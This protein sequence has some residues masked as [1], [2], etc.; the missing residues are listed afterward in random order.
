MDAECW[1]KAADIF[2]VALD[3]EGNERDA[4]VERATA[5]DAQVR[6]EV[7]VLLSSHER[8][9][10]FLEIAAS[11]AARDA[12]VRALDRARHVRRLGDYE[13]LQEIAAGGMGIVFRA[14]QISLNRIVALKTVVGGPLAS[15]GNV[16]RFQTEAEAAAQLDHPNIVPIYEVGE[17]DGVHYY[18]MRLIEGGSLLDRIGEFALP[19][20]STT[21]T[22]HAE[23]AA[24]QS[25]IAR[26][27]A[28]VA[29]GVHCAHQHGILHRD[30]KPANILIDS[31]GEPLI[32]DFGIAKL[33][34]GDGGA[35]RTATMIGTPNYMAP[36]QAAGDARALTTAADVFSLGAILY[37]LLTARQPFQ[38][39]T[40][41]E[42]LQRVVE[43]EPPAPRTCNKAIDRDL[44]T[45]C[46]KALLKNPAQRYGS[47]EAFAD[48][49]DRWLTGE[50]I[51]ARP[52]SPTERAWLWCRRKPALAA[53]SAGLL[54]SIVSGLVISLWQWRRAEGTA[55]L[56]AQNLYVSDV[57]V[58]FGAWESGRIE[59]ARELLNGQ[60]PGLG[61]PDLR[62]FEWRY[63]FGLTRPKELLTIQT[64]AAQIWG[65]AVSPDGR[66]LAT[67]AGD[68]TIQLWD[69]PSGA[70]LGSLKNSPTIIYCLAFSPVDGTLLAAATDTL[71][72][73]LWDVS[74]RQLVGR[75]VHHASTFS[76][77]F[78]PDGRK[79]ATVAGYPYALDTPA[80]LSL[81]D[82]DT[83]QKVRS[84]DAHQA[85][86]AFVDISRD[87]NL[88]AITSGDGSVTIW[89]LATHLPAGRL[90]GHKG[91]AICARFSPSG[92][93][94]ATGGIDGTVRL[95]DV[96]TGQMVA[97]LGSHEGAVYSVA[98][99][100]DGK[101]LLSG[102]LD[103][104]ARL[105][106]VS[107]QRPVGVL[108]GHGS[109][110]FSVSYA[111][112]GLTVVTASLDGTA[113]IWSSSDAPEFEIFDRYPG[114]RATVDFSPDG[115]WLA[116]SADRV[117]LWDA[118]RQEKIVDIPHSYARFSDDSSVLATTSAAGVT[119]WNVTGRVPTLVANIGVDAP[120]AR[121][122]AFSPD[123]QLLAVAI[124]TPSP[125]IEIR[126]VARRDRIAQL[127]E[128][129]SRGTIRSYA[130][131][132]D[133]L[134]LIA[135]YAD[136]RVRLWNAR[137]W[138]AG[139]LLD[140]H[141]KS[142]DAMAF[143]PDGRLFATGSL[144]TT[145][146][147]W[148]ATF[149]TAPVAL[150]GDNGAVSTLAFAP[151]GE[152]LAVGSVDATVKFWNVRT[153]REVATIKA[154][155][156]VVTSV[157]FSP[158]GRMLAT[159]S[160]DQTMKLWKAPALAEIGR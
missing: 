147:L 11:V 1:H 115:R 129:P 107:A 100:P 87:G 53:L 6:R 97:V 43:Q 123:G 7:D 133:G 153:R 131:S 159:A 25:R 81:W 4:F 109:R 146:Q 5:G 113:K 89:N 139:R 50:P 41:L 95:W 68:G 125:L 106:D 99:S 28:K 155:D 96:A 151:D 118:Q 20:P 71:E 69:L 23:M 54:L 61:Q 93:M 10:G 103:H 132:R 65:S 114:S 124:E 75:L 12:H 44:E 141:T 55:A 157:A 86:S 130:F 16:A 34:A 117:T 127:V 49:L 145:V 126:S 62:T 22:D 122:P 88:L 26:L 108:R 37:Q 51:A 137:T 85:S 143:S 66:I 105:W 140:A 134:R 78:T 144:D 84:F 128:T 74:K 120:P 14:R 56:M 21:I 150:R 29:R 112:D 40:P 158:D 138:T 39:A 63:L 9:G 92:S 91:M 104:T 15:A 52:T 83:R 154:H 149:E 2:L 160:V 116:R 33:L 31:Q 13:L 17:C 72:V 35:T 110:V 47:A 90:T 111:H 121:A 98:F 38:G 70:P 45:I 77:A 19:D 148:S 136:G 60:R 82:V 24:R 36:E 80:E 94:L 142:V 59:R 3:L 8:A 64:G 18:S 58:A 57:G 156:S 101:R 76:L 42:T 30:L 102:G 67:G 46:S 48:D 135:G 27:L 152:T 119:L 79:L 32:A 73:Q